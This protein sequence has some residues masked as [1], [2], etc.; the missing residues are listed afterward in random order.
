MVCVMVLLMEVQISM[1]FGHYWQYSW[2]L[3]HWLTVAFTAVRAGR[4]RPAR[5]MVS[6][7]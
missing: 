6:A 3:Y 7:G 1:S 2:W 4:P 5:G